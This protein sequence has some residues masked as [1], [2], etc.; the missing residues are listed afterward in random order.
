[1][2]R[3]NPT[4]NA[5]NPA[6]RWFEWNGERGDV[7]YFDRDLKENVILPLPFSFLLL[8]EL[9]TVRGWDDA[10]GSGIYAN[11]VRDTR[12]DRF[13]VKSFKGGTLASGLY[14]DIRDRI[15][16]IGG[17][18]VANCYIGFKSKPTDTDLKIGSLR[19]K[20]AALG[21]W[22]AFRKD[23]RKELFEQAVTISGFTE[24]KKG[25]IVYKMPE[26]A[27]KPITA[28]SNS[29]AVRLDEAL[30]EWL[31][32]YLTRSTD[33]RAELHDEEPE[34]QDHTPIPDNDSDIPF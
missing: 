8:D 26:F 4:V 15:H 20:G 19:F 5:P 32:S 6:V 14:K 22:M 16:T 3:S 31:E 18:F 27:L 34:P 1:M 28:E 2:S 13:V 12:T 23:H 10:S 25:R 21:A 33:D 17:K 9:A 30:Q 24:G 29:E 7:R 11:E